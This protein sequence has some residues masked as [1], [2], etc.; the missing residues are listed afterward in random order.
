MK[1]GKLRPDSQAGRSLGY[2][3]AL[4]FLQVAWGF[5]SPREQSGVEEGPSASKV[6]LCCLCL[7]HGTQQF[8]DDFQN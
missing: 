3:Q 7:L 4:D 1:Q 8:F 5:P 6:V 2:R